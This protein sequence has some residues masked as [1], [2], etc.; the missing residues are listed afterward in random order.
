M[1]LHGKPVRSAMETRV[2]IFSL[3]H[4]PIGR[5]T[6]AQP[7]TA[8]THVKYITRPQAARQVMAERMPAKPGP[9]AS[10]LKRAEMADRVNARVAD[11]VMLALPKEL[12]Q[13]QRVQLVRDFAN[14]V[15]RGKAPW[16]AAI[17]DRGKDAANPHCHLL[18]RDRDPATGR[19]VIGMSENG[20]TEMLREKWEEH[21]NRS[22]ARA[23]HDTRIDRRSLEAQ[24]IDRAP[25]IHEGPNIRA[26]EARGARPR[27]RVRTV[28]N[29]PGAR[30]PSRRV[31]YRSIDR[32]RTR[33]AYNR[34]LSAPET[35]T[36]YWDAIDRDQQRRE[37]AERGLGPDYARWE[38]QRRASSPADLASRLAS[39]PAQRPV[40]GEAP[41]VRMAPPS[42]VNL[43]VTARP[44]LSPAMLK[45]IADREADRGAQQVRKNAQPQPSSQTRASELL[46]AEKTPD[47]T[48]GVQQK[49]PVA[50][51]ASARSS[52]H[53]A[54]PEFPSPEV[55]QARQHHGMEQPAT[56]HETR[57]QRARRPYT[58]P[59]PSPD[60]RQAAQHRGL[61]Q[62]IPPPAAAR[63]QARQEGGT[64]RHP[65]PGSSVPRR[66][67]PPPLPSP[68]S[69]QPPQQQGLKQQEQP[70]VSRPAV[71][72]Q[73]PRPQM[74]PA[75][76]EVSQRSLPVPAP[77]IAGQGLHNNPARVL[78][79]AESPSAGT[80]KD[81]GSKRKPWMEM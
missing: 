35:E 15:T 32:G 78:P 71:P 17:H 81:F 73:R 2:A 69:R 80:S 6:Q 3:R 18:I 22:L 59:V 38:Q 70:P 20:S 72:P 51:P 23:G 56:E 50:P 76:R 52:K 21:A 34:S 4:T 29:G 49:A 77:S 46:P 28:R 36:D 42:K 43:P 24:G 53:R 66:P 47:Y 13:Q 1:G 27:S 54:T 16:I 44:Q 62:P 39:S 67:A 48:R 25:T 68:D 19:R 74:S 40:A 10:Y 31:D 12:S 30:Q 41:D 33:P 14:D 79:T 63:G 64:P 55:R 8:G 11:K 58:P 9:A 26:M 57:P 45:M 7:F 60:V 61:E 37:F 65:Q 5:S 75:L